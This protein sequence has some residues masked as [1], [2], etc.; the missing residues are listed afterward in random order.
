MLIFVGCDNGRSPRWK[1][2]TVT[3]FSWQRRTQGIPLKKIDMKGSRWRI[4]Q[5]GT[6]A[7]HLLFCLVPNKCSTT[8]MI[9]MIW[10]LMQYPDSL[11]CKMLWSKSFFRPVTSQKICQWWARSGLVKTHVVSLW[12][13]NLVYSE[14]VAITGRLLV[15]RGRKFMRITCDG[16]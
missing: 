10:M 3:L 15:S 11:I 5:T 2:I 7:I 8:W 14:V 12:Q 9:S 13:A 1:F 6:I 16:P 4:E